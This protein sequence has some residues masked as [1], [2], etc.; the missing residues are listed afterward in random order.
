M[1]HPITGND[2]PRTSTARPA[3]AP[4]THHP[5]GLTL[6]VKERKVLRANW[7][8]NRQPSTGLV[9]TSENVGERPAALHPRIPTDEDSW[10]LVAPS[11]HQDGAPADQ[12]H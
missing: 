3:S 2:T 6:G 12:H 1:A 11:L 4:E 10:Y 8:G 7:N 9:C 5:R